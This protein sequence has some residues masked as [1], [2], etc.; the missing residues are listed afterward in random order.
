MAKRDRTEDEAQATEQAAR[1][2]TESPSPET[3]PATRLITVQ[4]L[5]IELPLVFKPG[6]VCDFRDALFLSTMHMTSAMNTFA[7]RAKAMKAGNPEKNEAPATDEEIKAA[8]VEHFSTYS[9][10]PRGTA[11]VVDPVER[12]IRQIARAE[13]EEAAKA[14]GLSF[15][16]LEKDRQDATIAKHIERDQARLRA[17]AESR[18]ATARNVVSDDLLAG[19]TA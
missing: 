2:A 18:L 8:A 14:R 10:S 16:K 11:E 5:Q 9:W 12:M 6:H 1:A 13:I 19:L 15:R 17:E 3:F 7:E 4:G